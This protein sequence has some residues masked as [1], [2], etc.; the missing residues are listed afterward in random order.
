LDQNRTIPLVANAREC[1][2]IF[3]EA[4]SIGPNRHFARAV[5]WSFTRCPRYGASSGILPS[6]QPPPRY[7]WASQDSGAAQEQKQN[8]GR[9]ASHGEQRDCATF[10][11]LKQFIVRKKLRSGE[12]WPMVDPEFRSRTLSAV[13]DYSA[14]AC[15]NS[16]ARPGARPSCPQART[17]RASA[18][19]TAALN[20][21]LT[22]L[23]MRGSYRRF[24]LIKPQIRIARASQKFVALREVS[25]RSH[26]FRECV[27]TFFLLPEKASQIFTRLSAPPVTMVCPSDFQLIEEAHDEYVPS[28]TRKS[29]PRSR[30]SV[31]F[32]K[33]VRRH[34]K[35]DSGHRARIG[36]GQTVSMCNDLKAW[37]SCPI[38]HAP[39]S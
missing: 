29:L 38:S 11:A 35:R 26:L 19:A 39:N 23:R 7:R 10:R 9:I 32:A 4:G 28:S 6:P 37:T 17:R 21:T 3:R 22:L 36:E 15:P 31:I 12:S 27:G 33:R 24:S 5:R 34:P 8:R 25:E 18:V 1:K 20:G 16:P 13:M 14:A 30:I 2:N